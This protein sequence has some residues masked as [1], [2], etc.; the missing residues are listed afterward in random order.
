MRNNTELWLGIRRV[1][2][3][4]DQMLREVC[5]EYHLTDVYKRQL[6]Y[7]DGYM[8]ELAR[9]TTEDE[10][11]IVNSREDPYLKRLLETQLMTAILKFKIK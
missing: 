3:L 7:Y 5:E 1:L 11:G 6:Q 4:Y 10:W 8:A 2:K 9:Q